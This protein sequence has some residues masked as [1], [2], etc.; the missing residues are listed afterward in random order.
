[1]FERSQLECANSDNAGSELNVRNIRIRVS[2][3]RAVL[4]Q[5][6]GVNKEIREHIFTVT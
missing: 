4:F 2:S 3:R 5:R 6:G 1:M